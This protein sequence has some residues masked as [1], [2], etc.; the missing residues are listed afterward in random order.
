V[1]E[2]GKTPREA[3]LEQ[4]LDSLARLAGAKDE[5]LGQVAH[6]LRAQLGGVFVWL[7]MLRRSGPDAEKAARA[8]DAVESS[9]RRLADLLNELQDVM[10]ILSGKLSL[11]SQALRLAP[12]VESAV[13]AAQKGALAKGI[14]VET[15]LDPEAGPVSGD[16]SRL[17]QIVNILLSNAIK[18]TPENG[19]IWVRLSEHGQ[20]ALLSV[21][22][23]GAGISQDLLP[24]VYLRV[25]NPGTLDRSRGGNRGLGLT[26]AHELV[27]LHGG[28]LEA[29]SPG[30]GMG[31]TFT[32]AIPHKGALASAP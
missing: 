3:E 10:S 11:E 18:F 28:T 13:T 7:D 25:P 16:A 1:P 24:W 27:R 12:V 14:R 2:S 31:S 9:S 19:R 4:A 32:V 22:D 15:L 17:E 23:S 30:P 20:Q 5:F 8:M 26:I 21:T 6:D 29:E